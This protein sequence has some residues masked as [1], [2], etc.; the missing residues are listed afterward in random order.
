[1]FFNNLLKKLKK[2]SSDKSWIDQLRPIII[3]FKNGNK[4]SLTQLEV[5]RLSMLIRFKIDLEEGNT[6]NNDLE[7]ATNDGPTFH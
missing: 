6:S 4:E 3:D 7:Y 1:M 5:E 2:S